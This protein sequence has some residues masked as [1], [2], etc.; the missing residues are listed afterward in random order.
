MKTNR[1]S[2]IKKL[3]TGVAVLMLPAVIM[4]CKK[5]DI[6]DVGSANV[7]V[8]NA[9]TSSTPQSFHFAGSAVIQGGLAFGSASDYVAV[10]SGNNLQLRF[11]N[12]GSSSDYA[13]GSAS[14]NNGG[15]Y[16]VFLVGDGQNARVKTYPDNLSEP[17]SGKAKVRFIHLSDAAPANIDIRSNATTNV[18]ANLAKDNASDFLTVDP[19]VLSLQ[20]FAAGQST[21]VGTFDISAFAA[22][23]IYT[24]YV[25]GST[26]ETISV[27]QTAHD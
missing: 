4:S 7:K 5:D 12:E 20:I 19:G 16:T 18:V 27:R 24:V 15:F 23:Q 1:K 22:G 21:S 9:S 26:S 3:L 11:R 6:D 14:F 10:S 17:A 2:L 8:V 25:T 13:T